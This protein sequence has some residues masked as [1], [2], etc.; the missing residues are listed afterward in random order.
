MTKETKAFENFNNAHATGDKPAAGQP[1]KA[2][3]AVS[4]TTSRA[5]EQPTEQEVKHRKTVVDGDHDLHWAYMQGRNAR[6]NAIA[7][8][9]APH[10]AETDEYKAWIKGWNAG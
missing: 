6:A 1:V 3:K 4:D 10:D 8:E 5:P 9:D 2:E 7:K